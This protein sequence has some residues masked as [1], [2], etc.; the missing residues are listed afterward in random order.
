MRTRRF[1]RFAGTLW[2]NDEFEPGVGW[3]TER[4]ARRPDPNPEYVLWLADADGQRLT[5]G[6]IEL[7][8]QACRVQDDGMRAAKVLGYLPLHPDGRTVV[9]QHRD[10]VLHRA[11]LAERAPSITVSAVDIDDDQRVRVNW[12]AE[13]ERELWYSVVLLADGYAIPV[14]RDLRGT[15]FVF[16]T[17]DMPGGPR[18]AV[19]VLATDGYRSSQSRSAT[20]TLPERPVVVRILAPGDGETVAPDQPISLLGHAHDAAGRPAPDDRLVWTVDGV[21]AARGQRL[22][23]AGPFGPGEHRI[24]LAY[25]DGARAEIT[26]VVPE[27]SPA[28]REWLRMV[29]DRGSVD[30]QRA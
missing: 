24:E 21:P 30:V 15:E 16:P 2:E 13:H 12:R 11:E 23:L 9:F 28:Q 27:R 14:G 4:I 25:A 5:A 10:R 3:E 8:G 7:R 22:A 18:C 19:A 20:F 29:S 6:A 26:V 1:L 17:D